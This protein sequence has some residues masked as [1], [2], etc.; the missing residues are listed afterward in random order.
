MADGTSD[1]A[2]GLVS[3]AQVETVRDEPFA[4]AG[5]DGAPNVRS[6]HSRSV[7][8]RSLSVA[9]RVKILAAAGELLLERGVRAFTV[10]EVARRSGVAKTTI[11][12]HFDSGE[13]LIVCSLDAMV[14]PFPTPNT[15]SLRGDL[16]A[17]CAITS[18]MTS[19]PGVRRVVLDLLAASAGNPELAKIK[20]AMLEERQEPIRTI[21]QLAIAR[22]EVPAELDPHL[23]AEL[24]EA[25]FLSHLLMHAVDPPGQDRI[26]AMIDFVVAGLTG[27]TGR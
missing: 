1:C 10:D 20:R 12:R 13:Q 14:E 8:P 21:V 18:D 4:G 17:Y 25:P 11:Y 9:A 22:G 27:M 3:E 15:G 16:E 23:A 2:S 19:D 26:A 24:A 5:V 6:L 7:M